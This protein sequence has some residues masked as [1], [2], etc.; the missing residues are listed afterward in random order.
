MNRRER[1]MA[2]LQGRAVDRPAV[3]FYEIGGWEM[4]A[5]DDEFSVWN[6]PSW[7]PLIEMALAETDIIRMIAPK[8]TDASDGLAGLTRSESWREGD[9]KFRRTI[10]NAPGRELTSLTRRDKDTQTNWTL[11]HLLNSVEDA[12]AYLQLP[13]PTVG[14]VDVSGLLAEEQKLGDSGIISINFTDP[15]CAAAGLFPMED[16]TIIAMTERELFHRLLE[17]FARIKYAQCEQIARAM[18]GRL[19]RIVGPEYAAEPFLPPAMYEEYVVRYTG[20]LI[21]TIH[22]SGGYARV[23]SHGRLR[24]VLGHLAGMGIDALEPLEP[25]PQGDMELWEIKQAIGKD[26]VLM[27]NIEDADI[28]NLPADE[29]EKKVATAL[30]EGTAG[31]GRGFIL[32][33]S[34]APYGRVI[35]AGTTA[36]YK[37][38]IR[39][40]T[41]W[42]G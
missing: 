38:M 3:S 23:H 15:I 8:W 28:E 18:P 9:S 20:P 27:G 33:P 36:N 6:D 40:A 42:A 22:E 32:H 31:A 41:N 7:R 12:L 29:F 30:R 2:T 21:R 25:P 19:W 10:I 11:Q 17:R 14:K 5:N 4:A 16:Y 24:G 26:V 13:E 34:A 39:L 1:L 35:S 37:T